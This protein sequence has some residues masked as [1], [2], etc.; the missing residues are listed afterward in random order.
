MESKIK[1]PK[2]FN[3]EN[4][5]YTLIFIFGLTLIVVNRAIVGFSNILWIID[6]ASLCSIFY[7]I[8]TAKHS[9]WGLGF[10]LIATC[11]L[12]VSNSIQHI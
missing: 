7:V 3:K 6:I 2:L 9:V 11:V 4:I 1:A 10:D 12:V 5:I 8:F